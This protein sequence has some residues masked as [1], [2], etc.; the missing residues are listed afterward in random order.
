MTSPMVWTGV[1]P[2][3]SSSAASPRRFDAEAILIR[4]PDLRSYQGRLG[5]WWGSRSYGAAGCPVNPAAGWAIS[6]KLPG[7][8]CEPCV[9]RLVVLPERDHHIHRLHEGDEIQ[10]MAFAQRRPKLV[11][12][13]PKFPQI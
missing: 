1:M 12:L 6:P 13:R 10:R 8:T 2:V 7:R 4:S 5:H 11:R 9:R 3:A